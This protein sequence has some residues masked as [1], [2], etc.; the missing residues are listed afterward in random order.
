[1]VEHFLTWLKAKEPV[2]T[3]STPDE[4]LIERLSKEFANPEFVPRCDAG[5][6]GRSG[7]KKLLEGK[8]VSAEALDANYIRKSDAELFSAPKLGLV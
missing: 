1:L 5:M 3:V 6:I 8:T 2:P 7:L 4:T